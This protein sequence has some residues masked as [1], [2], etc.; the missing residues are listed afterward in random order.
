MRKNFQRGKGWG[1]TNNNLFTRL[2]FVVFLWDK[3]HKT[4]QCLINRKTNQQ[5]LMLL[6]NKHNFH[7]FQSVNYYRAVFIVL[8]VIFHVILFFLCFDWWKNHFLMQIKK[9]TLKINTS[10]YYFI[11]LFSMTFSDFN[12]RIDTRYIHL[13]LFYTYTL[14]V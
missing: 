1:V 13:P 2:F 10:F 7:I 5:E 14:H 12:N 8:I 11:D 9:K 3:I 6:E 4:H